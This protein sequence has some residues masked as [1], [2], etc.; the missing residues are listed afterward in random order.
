MS[1][2]TT[3]TTRREFLQTASAA[4]A[5]A[6]LGGRAVGAAE[7]A[8]K[9]NLP[10]N[11]EWR[12]KREG[13]TYRRLGRTNFMVSE[14]G[15]GC[16]RIDDM[17]KWLIDEAFDHGVNLFDTA[18]V[19]GKGQNEPMVGQAL[20]G[21]RDKVF[22]Q[23][24][25]SAFLRIRTDALKKKMYALSGAERRK[26]KQEA[27]ELLRALG[28]EPNDLPKKQARAKR[29]NAIR[30]VMERHFDSEVAPEVY[31][32]TIVKS[33]ESSLQ[34][35]QTDYVDILV[36]PH[37]AN[38]ETAE[39]LKK[40]GKIRALG[41]TTHNSMAETCL[42]AIGT[43]KYDVIVPAINVLNS[44]DLATTLEAAKTNDVGVVAMK[45]VAP[46]MA[47]E[48]QKAK[49]P[50]AEK[51]PGLELL[52]KGEGSIAFRA[53]QWAL[54]EPAIHTVIP[55]VTN[56][57]QLQEDLKLPQVK[58]G[59]LQ[60]VEFQRY[61]FSLVPFACRMCGACGQCPNGVAVADVLR[62]GMY[63]DVHG[64]AE[65]ARGGYR[66]LTAEQRADNCQ[67]CGA[68]EAACPNRLPLRERLQEIHTAL[69]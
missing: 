60:R 61:A 1:R 12:N 34:N 40:Q 2:N 13:M 19:Y 29:A 24:K 54:A 31:A 27:D 69:A 17:T 43:G 14:V 6:L 18:P 28:I 11:V 66:G 21:K 55:G 51:R 3:P 7:G 50:Q 45:V 32:D 25:I 16:M 65:L 33:L 58:M 57:Q 22:V 39:K 68:C 23:T 4:G 56:H 49:A 35:L 30:Q 48:K 62:F 8:P 36:C 64:D 46:L 37:G 67:S 10:P 41:V 15:L 47:A 5:G 63:L 59:W 52:P 9:E 26:L 53:L 20:K 44:K 38:A 42:A